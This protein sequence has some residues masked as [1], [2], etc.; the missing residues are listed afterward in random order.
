MCI[1]LYIEPGK[2]S[3]W[4]N[5]GGYHKDKDEEEMIKYRL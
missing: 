2:R 3:G 5:N 1:A 4:E